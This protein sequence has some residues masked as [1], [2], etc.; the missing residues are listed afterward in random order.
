MTIFQT[1]KKIFS[2]IYFDRMIAKGNLKQFLIVI[3]L[4][5]IAIF[6]LGLLFK[7]ILYSIWGTYEP[8]S[9][10]KDG[11]FWDTYENY[12]NPNSHS[13]LSFSRRLYMLIAGIT[14]VF[15]L[16]GILVSAI[17]S[18]VE[19]RSERWKMGELRY[20][21]KRWFPK[22]FALNNF[23]VVIGGNEMVPELVRQILCDGN[24][25]YVLVM[26][27]RDVSSLRKKIT[28]V[29]GSDEEKVILYNGERTLKDDLTHLQIERAN[30][31]YII[32]EQLD[33]EQ[34]GSHHDVKNMECVKLM[35][36]I[37]SNNEDYTTLITKEN[38][39][40]LLCRVMFE[41]QSSFSVFQFTDVDSKISSVL[42]FKP[43]NYYETWAQNVLICPHI[44]IKAENPIYLPLEGY[45]PITEDSNSTV[46][47]IVVGMSRMGI[48]LGIEAA[49]IAHYPN[50][51]KHLDKGFRTRITFIDSSAKQ[52][53]QYMQGHYKEL[54]A[55]SRWR[56]VEACDDD[57]YYNETGHIPYKNDSTWHNPLTDTNS[58]SP[59]RDQ[60]NYSLGKDFID[61]E[62]EFIQG[63][64]EMPSVQCYIREAAM[65]IDERLTIAICFPK[66][67]ASFAASLYLPDEVY[68]ECNNVVQVLAY[69]PYGDAMCRS[70][71]DRVEMTGSNVTHRRNNFNQFAKLKAFGMIDCCYNISQQQK[72]E[73]AANQLWIQYDKT[74][75]GRIGGRNELRKL[76]GKEL[77]LKA[78]KSLAAKQWS[79]TYAAAHLWTKLRSINWDCRAEINEQKQALLAK[80]EHIRWNVEQ[81]LLGFAPLR[82]V[83]QQSIREKLRK[84]KECKFP[85]EELLQINNKT[86]KSLDKKLFQELDHWLD[87]WK[88]FDEERE[89][90]KA[91]MSHIDICSYDIL[92][93]ID[94]EAIKYD[95]DLT[96]ILPEIYKQIN[97]L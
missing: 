77:P 86:D 91:S 30:C 40:K 25:S 92:K 7:F 27:N 1:I 57:I 85:S 55:L 52:E 46:H 69:Q 84:A 3:L 50:F 39:G 17:V 23:V 28:S 15:L 35:S 58:H 34:S 5:P 74:Y 45:E 87:A 14:G 80:M 54:F 65:N 44:N 31:V 41:Y 96:R 71:M 95:I 60:E 26:T 37:L 67:N 8:L 75:N 48:A 29:L 10:V 68:D 20:D 9:I 53:M 12:I 83:E 13:D 93:T 49:H 66:D 2:P 81:L 79:N 51:V 4:L 18:W 42:E 73:L 56:Y 63:N 72:M 82:P 90:L 47:L 61:V 97:N 64:L 38:R 43:F 22:S 88:E 11:L 32:G 33:I 76:F 89:I 16:N 62:W 21:K 59:Y 24:T 19:K 36:D 70:F 94:E 78:G 6:G